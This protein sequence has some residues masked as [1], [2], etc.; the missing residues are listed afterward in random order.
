MAINCF[1]FVSFY[2]VYQTGDDQIKISVQK[3]RHKNA[4]IFSNNQVSNNMQP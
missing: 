2:N 4:R 3:D 1:H